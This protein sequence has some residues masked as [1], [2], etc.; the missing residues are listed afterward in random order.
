MPLPDATDI[1]QR[2]GWY[3]DGD[4][5]ET[6]GTRALDI[7]GDRAERKARE[8][9]TDDEYEDIAGDLPD[10]SGA[11]ISY[12]GSE[13]WRL[14]H[15]Y[16]AASNNVGIT[17]NS[18]T[19]GKVNVDAGRP[20][21]A[22]WHHLVVTFDSSRSEEVEVHW[23]GARTHKESVTD[24]GSGN[25]RYGFMGVES[26]ATSYDGTKTTGAVESFDG[27]IDE[28]L[29]LVGTALSA[30]EISDLMK[31][32]RHYK[33]HTD[34]VWKYS[35]EAKSKVED[36]TGNGNDLEIQS[37]ALT[38]WGRFGKALDLT[39]GDDEYA[40]ISHSHTASSKTD[41]FTIACWVNTEPIRR[42]QL[43]EAEA[44]LAAY[45]AL[46]SLNLRMTKKG[47]LQRRTGLVENENDLMSQAEM[48]AYRQRWLSD[49]LDT[50]ET[51]AP[52]DSVEVE[53]G[54]AI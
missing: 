20:L 8:E 34:A 13:Y 37:G 2:A 48:D 54:Y 50:L 11:I 26:G 52:S 49:A 4:V 15:G 9:I 6:I 33:S 23:D 12:D 35:F 7:A 17:I 39:G 31:N 30:T 38:T 16:G 10:T 25:E 18:P 45:Y 1:A 53:P 47:G 42:E 43:R 14:E 41:N 24:W 46:P 21:S 27:R 40:T 22:G 29:Y 28:A 5:D 44:L 32:P 36:Q 51:L 3:R 19:D